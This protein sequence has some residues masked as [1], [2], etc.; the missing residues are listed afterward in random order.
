MKRPLK[1]ALALLLA[2]TLVLGP[3]MVRLA[4]GQDDNSASSDEVSLL[5]QLAKDGYLGEKKDFYLAAKS[6]TDDDVTD[7]L[8]VIDDVLSKVDSK[9]LK[10]G[11]PEYPRADLQALLKLV[12]DKADD[13]RDR[14][15]SAWRFENHLKKMIAAL[16]PQAQAAPAAQTA[17]S[18]PTVPA[19]TP[20]VTPIPGPSR[21]EW[22]EMKGTLKDLEKKTTDMQDAYDNKIDVLQKTSDQITAS[23]AD[24]LE[25]LKLVKNL[26]D[27]VQDDLN[28]TGEHLDEVEK[29]ASEKSI[30][31]TELEQELTIMHKDL[32]DN[33]LDVG[34]LKEEVAKLSKEDAQAGESPLDQFLGSKWLAGG[35]LVVGLTALVVSLTRK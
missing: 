13:I 29:K 3:G 30:S 7:G 24:N 22:E 11:M 21:A 1:S 32:R 14:K 19:P 8:L 16:S 18:T 26:L 17:A 31:D 35:A 20:T 10:P 6:L 27:R 5:Q 12:E 33:S 25:Q 15:V 9:S 4:F 2:S 23:N 34:I 28:K